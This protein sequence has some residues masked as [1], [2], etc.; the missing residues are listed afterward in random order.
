MSLLCEHADL[1]GNPG[2]GFHSTRFMGM[3]AYDLFGTIALAG[4]I[5]W[6]YDY[7]FL[8][9]LLVVIAIAIVVHY[10]FGVNTALNK[11]IFGEVKCDTAKSDV[12]K[13]D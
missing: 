11:K 8:I 5:A 9:V 2:E 12:V 6:Y 4:G 7:S 10:L 13:T 3:A 1:F